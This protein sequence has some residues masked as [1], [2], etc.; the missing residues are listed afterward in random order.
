MECSVRISFKEL[1]HFLQLDP[2]YKHESAPAESIVNGYYRDNWEDPRFPAFENQFRLLPCKNE[3]I[4]ELIY[5]WCAL[6]GLRTYEPDSTKEFNIRR[7][8]KE[9]L[10]EFEVDQDE[11][12]SFL[13]KQDLPLPV[14]FFRSERDNTENKRSLENEEF[15]QIQYELGHVLPKLEQDLEELKRIQP[16][17]MAA[18]EKKKA[19]LRALKDKI[20]AIHQGT[21]PVAGDGTNPRSLEE[22][23][24]ETERTHLS[25]QRRVNELANAHPSMSHSWIA[26]QVAKE[27]I[28]QG[29]S[30]DTIRRYTQKPRY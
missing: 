27:P 2:W 21:P 19:E 18:R 12:K 26:K 17:S 11:I 1:H 24:R 20:H 14:H 28:A 23:K 22:K 13:R 3:R 8:P 15:V 29:R 9:W 10:S 25:W 16:E 6:L 5:L 7:L 4:R 30:A